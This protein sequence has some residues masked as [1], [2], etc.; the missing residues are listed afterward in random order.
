MKKVSLLIG[1]PAVRVRRS[2]SISIPLARQV[3]MYMQSSTACSKRITHPV[4][5]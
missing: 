2:S 1:L 5:K 3:V 4:G